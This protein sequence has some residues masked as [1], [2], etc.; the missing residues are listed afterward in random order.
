[1]IGPRAALRTIVEIMLIPLLLPVAVL[2]GPGREGRR[3]S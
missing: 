2:W 1:M 3:D